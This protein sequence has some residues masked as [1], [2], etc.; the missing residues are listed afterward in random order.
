MKNTTFEACLF[1]L[2]TLC[3]NP[4][5]EEFLRLHGRNNPAYIYRNYDVKLNYLKPILIKKCMSYEAI[6]FAMF[7]E[8][9]IEDQYTDC[10]VMYIS[11]DSIEMPGAS[12]VRNEG[13]LDYMISY[14]YK[15]GYCDDIF[16]NYELVLDRVYGINVDDEYLCDKFNVGQQH[17][18]LKLYNALLTI[19]EDILQ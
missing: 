10:K 14:M 11:V 15:C 17:K 18:C 8:F 9:M 2:K 16:M 1:V 3:K 7:L 6:A 19:V 13:L 4:F 12:I 5:M